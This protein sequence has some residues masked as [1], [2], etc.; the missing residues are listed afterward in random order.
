MG[1]VQGVKN[2][3]LKS[4]VTNPTKIVAV[5][6]NYHEVLLNSQEEVKTES[7]HKGKTMREKDLFLKANTSLLGPGEGITLGFDGRAN[8]LAVELALVIGKVAKNI[9]YQDALNV[10]AGYAIG[11]NS[12]LQ[13]C[14]ETSLRQSID[15]FSVLGPWVTTVDEI[16]DPDDLNFHMLVNG[17]IRQQSSTKHLGLDCRR[18]IELACRFYTL[19]PGDIIMTGAYEAVEVVKPGDRIECYFDIIGEMEVEVF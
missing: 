8:Y 19:Y 10:L 11:L 5:S 7:G 17:E 12:T 15:S 4:P 14:E 13:G 9:C 3:I 6:S 16:E 18:L 1:Y 2:V